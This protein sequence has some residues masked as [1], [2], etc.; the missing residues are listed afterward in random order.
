M[1]A[2]SVQACQLDAK[3]YSNKIKNVNKAN[4]EKKNVICLFHITSFAQ[5]VALKVN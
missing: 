1:L 5:I 3:R 2:F 4:L